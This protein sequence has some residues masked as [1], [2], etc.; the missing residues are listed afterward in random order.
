M[1]IL[2]AAGANGSADWNTPTHTVGD[3]V[4]INGRCFRL[5]VG[6]GECNEV[7]SLLLN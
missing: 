4:G 5:A 1:A 7:Y 3:V 2:F 6:T